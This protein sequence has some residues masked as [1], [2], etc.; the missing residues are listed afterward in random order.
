[1]ILQAQPTIQ[2]KKKIPVESL[3]VCPI[4]A[5]DGPTLRLQAPDRF[6]MRTDTYELRECRQCSFVWLDNMPALE[7]MAYHYGADYHRA[8]T[9]SGETKL[10]KRWRPTRDKV[11]KMGRG[12]ALLDVGCSSGGF[13]RTL[14]GGPWKLHG[15]EISPDEARKAEETSGAEVFVGTVL[16]APFV[17][18]RFDVITAFHFLE[19]AHKLKEVVGRMWEWLKPGG[20]IYIQVPNIEGFEAH[21]FKSYWYGLELPRHLWHFSPASLRELFLPAGF[22][23]VFV[24][25]APDCYVEKS[26]RYLLDNAFTKVGVSRTP[27]AAMN[28]SASIPRRLIRKAVRLGVL[29]PFRQASAAAG[30]GAAIDAMF[31]KKTS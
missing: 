8:V 10:L 22:E 9:A 2:V 16:D 6:H 27:L 18:Q 28:G 3:K 21:I 23:E 4:C 26:V 7:E 1:M 15:L 30:R 12:D 29:W 19:H 20:I 17:P 11:L 5:S 24:R 14:Q 25:T 31:R 13:L